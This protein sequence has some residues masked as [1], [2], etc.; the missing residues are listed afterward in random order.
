MN[1][2]IPCTQK[3]ADSDKESALKNYFEN[4]LFG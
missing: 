1:D 2:Y 3:K 4:D